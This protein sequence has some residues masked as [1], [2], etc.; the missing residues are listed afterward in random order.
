[1][2][3]GGPFFIV[4]SPRS[5]TGLLRDLVRAHPAIEIP[6]ESHFIPP[7]FHGYRD[8]LSE[9]T[10]RTLARRILALRWVRAWRLDLAPSDFAGCRTYA[11]I[12]G[13]M[14]AAYAARSAK[15]RWGD[16][17]P[18]YVREIPALRALFPDCR[19]LHIHR[20]GRDVWRSWR[21]TSFGPA[22][23]YVAAKTWAGFVGAGRAAG[24]NLDPGTYMEVRY[25]DLLA[26]PERIMRAVC[27][28][29][30]ESFDPAMLRPMAPPIGGWRDRP[31]IDGEIARTNSGRWRAELPVEDRRVFEAIAG[32]ELA[33][34]GYEL[35]GYDG[36]VGR[37]ARMRWTLQER[38]QWVPRRLR[39]DG[40]IRL[41]PHVATLALVWAG[42]RR[43]VG[44]GR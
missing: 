24:R 28:F 18:Q 42:V 34:L 7:L 6:S 15:V 25:E 31:A 36:G 30:G 19:V 9:R 17:T 35:E 40:V 32:S 43:R 39:V 38:A 12:V 20:D 26:D 5:G 11:E 2:S 10:A 41:A 22:N 29:L 27:D 4:G 23:A 21:A 8:P 13:R 3:E 37:I 1:M 44:L 33:D 16:K 14:Y